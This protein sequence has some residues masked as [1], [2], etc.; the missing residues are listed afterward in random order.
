M[1][2]K[3]DCWMGGSSQCCNCT[4]ITLFN[5]LAG[6]SKHICYNTAY[7]V[8]LYKREGSWC[9]HKTVANVGGGGDCHL[10]DHHSDINIY[11]CLCVYWWILRQREMSLQH[12]DKQRI[13]VT[14]PCCW[15]LFWAFGSTLVFCQWTLRG[16]CTNHLPSDLWITVVL[17][18]PG[19]S[20]ICVALLEHNS[21][22]ATP[23]F[24]HHTVLCVVGQLVVSDGRFI[25]SVTITVYARSARMYS[26]KPNHH[27]L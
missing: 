22:W 8:D 12:D 7:S 17:L 9:A 4:V 3:S 19:P 18:K 1:A 14:M 24:P 5:E 20:L 10:T 25:F 27:P 2:N 21:H 13:K 16:Q 15:E 23:Y 6:H 26:S 11:G